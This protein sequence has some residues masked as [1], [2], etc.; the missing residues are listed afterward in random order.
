MKT[1][2]CTLVIG[3]R[4]EALFGRFCLDSWQAFCQ[5][6]GYTLQIFQKPFAAL[7][8]KSFAWQ[9]LLLLE[10]PELR[11]FD[12]IVWVDADIIIKADAPA[13]GSPDGL[14]G[15]VSEA[16]YASSIRSWYE[17]FSLAPASDIVQTG[18]LCLEHA[19]SSILRDALAY[20]ETT[21]FEMPSLSWHV[22]NSGLGFRL[23]ARFN[24][25]LPLLIEEHVPRWMVKNKPIKEALWKLRYPPLRRAVREVCEKN[26]FIHAAGAKRDLEKASSCLAKN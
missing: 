11:K 22:S 19:H 26:W 12:K 18:V 3:P 7:P 2:I 17:R 25:I 20:P 13:I 4:F 24:A 5:A 9:K 6:H 15:Y 10:Q 8:G 1:A 16:A 23:D 21:I 14:I